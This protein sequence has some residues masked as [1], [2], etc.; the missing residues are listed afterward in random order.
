MENGSTAASPRA[1]EDAQRHP[2]DEA[3]KGSRLLS[4]WMDCDT[5]AWRGKKD[6]ARG[7]VIGDDF[8]S[9]ARRGCAVQEAAADARNGCLLSVFPKAQQA[10]SQGTKRVLTESFFQGLLCKERLERPV[11]VK[12]VSNYR[13]RPGQGEFLRIR[14]TRAPCNM[15]PSLIPIQAFFENWGTPSHFR[16]NSQ[17]FRTVDVQNAVKSLTS[18]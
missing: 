3:A 7:G 9:W 18:F 6:A 13:M 5:A 12:P 4:S 15:C 17:H 10:V 2:K 8:W 14:G 1:R 11:S 16:T